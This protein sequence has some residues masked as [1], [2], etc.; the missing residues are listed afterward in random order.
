MIIKKFDSFYIVNKIKEH[1]HNKDNLLRLIDNMPKSSYAS[2]RENVQKTD[3][4]LSSDMERNY[5]ELFYDMI[6][7]YMDTMKAEMH[8]DIWRINNGWYQQY[9]GDNEHKWHNHPGTNFSNVYFLEMPEKQM[10]TQFYNI[11]T[12]SI[13]TFDLEEGDLLTFP[14]YL[15]HRSNK[16]N[17]TKRKTIISFNSD[18]KDVRL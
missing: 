11:L 1:R 15:L 2:H 3:W 17:S 10:Q 4:N 5:L 18:F 9:T 6:T 16:I 14:A 8:C 12:K 7:P 13:V